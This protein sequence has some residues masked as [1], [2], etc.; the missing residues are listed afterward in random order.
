MAENPEHTSAA[1]VAPSK[2]LQ[3]P[4]EGLL[5][6]SKGFQS[7]PSCMKRVKV[8][9]RFIIRHLCDHLVFDS[10]SKARSWLVENPGHK[11]CPTLWFKDNADAGEDEDAEVEEGNNA[12]REMLSSRSH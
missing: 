5:T 6:P 9:Q 4:S 2:V 11:P 8:E 10:I 7:L 12:L 3:T 1:S